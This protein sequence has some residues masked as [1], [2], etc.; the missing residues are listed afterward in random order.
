MELRDRFLLQE[1]YIK[2][3]Q[4][5]A[6]LWDAFTSGNKS[7]KLKGEAAEKEKEEKEKEKYKK[8]IEEE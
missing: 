1:R 8:K 7:D 3:Q 6:F 5:A 2:Y 4:Q